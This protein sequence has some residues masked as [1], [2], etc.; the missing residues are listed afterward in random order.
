MMFKELTNRFDELNVD[1]DIIE[2]TD[3][4][5]SIL[6]NRKEIEIYFFSDGAFDEIINLR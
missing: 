1:Y 3:G 2:Y 5:I 6:L 4:S